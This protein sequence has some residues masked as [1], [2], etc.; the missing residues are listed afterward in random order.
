MLQLLHNNYSIRDMPIRHKLLAV[1]VV[2]ALLILLV[3]AVGFQMV[4]A[5]TNEMLY[6]QTASS[7]AVISDKVA[8]RLNNLVD[9]SLYISTNQEF[10]SNLSVINQKSQTSAR[11]VSRAKITSLLYRTFHSDI[12]TMS[13][14]PEK[15]NSIVLGFDSLPE[16]KTVYDNALS[17]AAEAKGAAVWLSADRSDG[18]ILLARKI[19]NMKQP[20]LESMGLLMFRVNLDKIVT[21]CTQD[22]LPGKYSLAINQ[23]G[24]P[25]YPREA[26]NTVIPESLPTEVPYAIRAVQGER[27][28][29]AHSPIQTASLNWDFLLAIPYTDVFRSLVLANILF[30][31]CLVLAVVV[32]MLLSR[33]LFGSIN[34]DITLL[35]AKMNQVRKGNLEPYRTPASLGGDELG[36]LNRHFDEMTADFKQVIED[37]YIKQLLLAQTQL[38]ALEQQINP[39]FLYN[40]LESINWFARSGEGKQVSTMVQALGHLLRN[41][42]SQN[43]DRISLRQEFDILDSYLSIQ[44]IRFPDTLRVSLQADE[45]A[46]EVMIPKMS[47]QPLVENAIIHSLEENVGK[48]HIYV[49]AALTEENLLVEV[50]NDGSQIDVNMLDNLRERKAQPK[51]HGIGL[52]NIDSRIKLLFGQEYGLRLENRKQRVV[53]S[54]SIPA[55]IT[56]NDAVQPNPQGIVT[57]KEN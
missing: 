8:S 39:H 20:F 22:L 48:C 57:T 49:R 55:N 50:E 43:E 3:S 37:N 36:M 18:S 11:A 16:D 26:T 12:V 27:Y 10:Q 30:V 15:S 51:G 33:R 24:E 14:F 9:I 28:F 54:F 56:E 21:E 45:E 17:A 52:I 25:L 6:T 7:L 29:V 31:V 4:T 47:I 23:N 32:A 5:Q 46:M 19:Y 35:T 40:V 34:R 42:L 53:V 44:R 1:T 41:T 13:I 38:K 2:V